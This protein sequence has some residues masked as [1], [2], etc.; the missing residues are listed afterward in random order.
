MCDCLKITSGLCDSSADVSSNY[1][2]L[3]APSRSERLLD[4]LQVNKCLSIK[5]AEDVLNKP[6]AFE[7]STTEDSMF[8]IAETV[9][10][11][12]IAFGG[13]SLI[14]SNNCCILQPGPLHSAGKGGLDKRSWQGNCEA[15]K[16]VGDLTSHTCR[17]PAIYLL[18]SELNGGNDNAMSNLIF[19]V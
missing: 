19:P 12:L 10:V 3:Y 6:H 1:M 8:F 9:K 4:H 14:L 13:P 5:G 18:I 11:G 15:F 17:T 16:K 7:I 2:P